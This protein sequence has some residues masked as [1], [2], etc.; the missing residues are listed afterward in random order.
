M[1]TKFPQHHAVLHE[2]VIGDSIDIFRAHLEE[3]GIKIEQN[4]DVVFMEYR[5]LGVDEARELV[6]L[7]LRAPVV[8]EKKTII[9]SI[10]DITREA[11][12]ALLKLFEDPNP[13]VEFRIAMENSHALLPTLRSRLYVTGRA[14]EGKI[15]REEVQKF[16]KMGMGERLK[17]VEKI[18]KEQKDTGS[19][20]EARNFL[21]ALI[22]ELERSPVENASAL[23]A[24]AQALLYIDDKGASV[25]LLL[26]SVALAI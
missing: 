21:K 16:L 1:R 10:R 5:S 22:L 12:N 25:K 3:T 7:A 20:I 13:Q 19:K 15:G 26:E 11:Q 2:G 4:P 14:E 24:S 17:E 8:E 6:A 9:L 18:L 23:C